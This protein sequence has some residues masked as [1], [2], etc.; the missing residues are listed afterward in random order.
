[1]TALADEVR[2]KYSLSLSSDYVERCVQAKASLT[3]LELY[4]K[5]LW[6]NLRDICGTSLLPYGIGAQVS[7]TLPNAVVMQI[8]V[9]RDATQPLR[10]C[11]D[12]SDEEA[13]LNAAFQRNSSKRLLRL[14]LTDG[15]IEVPAVELSTLR[16]FHGI[17]TP[18]EKVLI[19]K[20]AEVRN[21]CI[22]LSESNVSLLGGEVHQLKQDFLAHRRRL[23]A[24]YQTSNGLDGAPRFAPLEVGHR[25]HS[26]VVH[27]GAPVDMGYHGVALPYHANERGGMHGNHCHSGGGGGRAQQTGGNYGGHSSGGDHGRGGR[28]G[29]GSGG[30]DRSYGGDGW[31]GHGRGGGRDGRRGGGGSVDSRGRVGGASYHVDTANFQA[32]GE[33]FPEINEANFPRLV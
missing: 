9:S 5:S 33:K 3:S 18:G 29:R 15:N 7:A 25:C 4:Q 8:N 27:S 1:M 6:E 16:V 14:Q 23:E 21:G 22:I 28:G 2:G 13:I 11:A 20:D 30:G 12:I 19:H 10:P 24:G 17:P 26:S 32:S 31:R